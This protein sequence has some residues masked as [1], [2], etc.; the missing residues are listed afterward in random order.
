MS[1]KI[2]AKKNTGQL[3]PVRIH[4]THAVVSGA[5][6]AGVSRAAAGVGAGV[7]EAAVQIAAER[8]TGRLVSSVRLVI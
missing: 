1:W 3:L 5:I 2:Q 7:E 6:G 4:G 8:A